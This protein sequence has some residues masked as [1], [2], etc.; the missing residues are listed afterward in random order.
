M[1][2]FKHSARTMADTGPGEPIASRASRLNLLF[3]VKNMPGVGSAHLRFVCVHLRC[4]TAQFL[5]V[6]ISKHT[7][8]FLLEEGVKEGDQLLKFRVHV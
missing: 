2:K 4:T 3:Q 7:C 5:L 1:L 6:W 8:G